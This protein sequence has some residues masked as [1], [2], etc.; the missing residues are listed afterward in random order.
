MGCGVVSSV[1]PAVARVMMDGAMRGGPSAPASHGACGDTHRARRRRPL[2]CSNAGD[3]IEPGDHAEPADAGRRRTDGKIRIGAPGLDNLRQARGVDTGDP[4]Q[5]QGA[6]RPM[7]GESPDQTR[8]GDCVQLPG[9][10]KQARVDRAPGT[11]RR[12]SGSP[13][14]SD[15]VKTLAPPGPTRRPTTIST[16]PSRICPRIAVMTPAM[17]KITAR[18]QSRVIMRSSSTLSESPRVATTIHITSCSGGR[19]HPEG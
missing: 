14:T 18:I 7:V 8:H 19:V 6:D 5:I 11:A 17:T 12:H 4:G 15:H 1:M 3:V 16:M 10:E 13:F 2:S 9:N